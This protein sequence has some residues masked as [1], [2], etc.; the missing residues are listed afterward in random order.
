VCLTGRGGKN[1]KKE[2]KNQMRCGGC[3]DKG[4]GIKKIPCI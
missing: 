1:E 2:K 3:V 4:Q